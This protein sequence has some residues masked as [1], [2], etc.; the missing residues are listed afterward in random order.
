MKKK[1]IEDSSKVD[2]D[3]LIADS[4]T[5]IFIANDA[6]K[7]V[8]GIQDKISFAVKNHLSTIEDEKLADTLEE[9]FDAA[10]L[11]LVDFIKQV[12]DAD[13]TQLTT[14]KEDEKDSRLGLIEVIEDKFKEKQEPKGDPEP[15]ED[16]HKLDTA[17]VAAEIEV[18]MDELGLG[19][20]KVDEKK[21]KSLPKTSFCIA[22]KRG[23]SG[24]KGYLPVP[25]ADYV[26]AT[27]KYL[28]DC[29][30]SE[31]T[32]TAA[33]EVLDRKAKVL[34]ETK[35]VDSKKT[36]DI[37][38]MSNEDL[39]ELGSKVFDA[40]KTKELLDECPGCDASSKEIKSLE[41]KIANQED[42]LKAI[43]IEL[44]EAY[45]EVE[46]L[47]LFNIELADSHKD[48]MTQSIVDLSSLKGEEV[49]DEKVNEIKNKS[50]I[51]MT[52]MFNSIKD[53][54]NFVE[55]GNRIANGMGNDPNGTVSDP[56]LQGEDGG[57]DKEVFERVR[58][59]YFELLFGKGTL[60]AYDYLNKCK[61]KGLIP[62]DLSSFETN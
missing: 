59:Q 54:V 37:K 31:D 61:A 45:K 50:V 46:E 30:L 58:D 2:N 47:N 26:T 6:F 28:E 21:R 42:H 23:A 8:E 39:K 3:K 43:R 4:V 22:N 60:V 19:E 57:F 17:A 25:N 56:T 10:V 41:D 33:T 5:R 9:D 27:R 24:D 34:G 62:K 20:S 55:V 16:L 29:E 49:N 38:D 32:I 7:D 36:V 35:I 13:E 53:E 1:L 52:D 18:I 15:L 48:F 12:L 11:G 51:D 40:L 44:Q 14:L